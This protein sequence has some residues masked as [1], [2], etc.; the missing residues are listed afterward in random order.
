[1]YLL[2][3]MLE[4]NT[5][6]YSIYICLNAEVRG[7]NNS[8]ETIKKEHEGEVISIAAG[9]EIYRFKDVIELTEKC[10]LT[11]LNHNEHEVL[12]K[13]HIGNDECAAQCI[14][15]AVCGQE[16]VFEPKETMGMEM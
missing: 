12:S 13:L 16:M 1:M 5:E 4:N 9:N 6:P 8:I 15:D 10:Q 3:F 7:F 14:F 2:K 11:E